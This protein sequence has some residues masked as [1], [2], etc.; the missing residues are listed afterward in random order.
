MVNQKQVE[1]MK[2]RIMLS[3]LLGLLLSLG[4][5]QQPATAQ[6]ATQQATSQATFQ[7]TP[8]AIREHLIPKVLNVIPHDTQSYTEGL[9][10]QDGALYESAGLYMQSSVREVNPKTG[11]IIRQTKLDTAYFGEGLT[12]VDGQLIQLTWKEGTAFVYDAKTFKPVREFTY[13]GE[14]WGL[15]YDGQQLYM[16]NGSHTITIRDPHTFEITGTIQVLL[17]G[18]PVEQ[19]NELECVDDSVYSNVWYTDQILR[20]DK[21]TGQVTATIDASGLLNSNE[22]MVAGS[23]GVLNGISYDP[24]ARTFLITGKRWPWMFEVQFVPNPAG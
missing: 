18:T 6:R 2:R 11:E 15:C 19:L 22:K 9:V 17:N 12:F 14:G 10:W 13:E 24:V 3:V 23:D 21:I 7:A 5:L 8:P 20:I 4:L 1:F 16:S